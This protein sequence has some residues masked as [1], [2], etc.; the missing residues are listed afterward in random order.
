MNENTANMSDSSSSTPP[1][2]RSGVWFNEKRPNDVFVI[3]DGGNI[4]SKPM[5]AL[6]FPELEDASIPLSAKSGDFGPA[7]KDVRD[8]DQMMSTRGG[9]R[10]S[11]KAD[12]HGL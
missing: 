5:V 10:G 7:E 12:I 3:D 4:S 6:D 1:S 9:E 8:D 11:P 2:W